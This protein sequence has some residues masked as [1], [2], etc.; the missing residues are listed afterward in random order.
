MTSAPAAEKAEARYFPPWDHGELP[1]APLWGWRRWTALIGPGL[2]MAGSNIGGGE[3]L[4]GPIVT[5]RYGG[6]IMWLAATSILLQ[7]F[8]NLEVMRYAMYTGEP[9]L[10]GLFRTSPGRRSGR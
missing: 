9:I 1:P 7:V 4:F 3:W 5:A 10:V 2:L 8:Y 6:G